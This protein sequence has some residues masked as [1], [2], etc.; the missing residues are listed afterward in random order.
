MW[1]P[2]YK[3]TY[4]LRQYKCWLLQSSIL[5]REIPVSV[6]YWT[7][8]HLVYLLIYLSYLG[9]DVSHKSVGS[10][11]N[12]AGVLLL[13]FLFLLK[14]KMLSKTLINH[15]ILSFVGGALMKVG[16]PGNPYRVVG[17]K[18]CDSVVPGIWH[19]D[20]QHVPHGRHWR[21]V[22]VVLITV[23]G[24]GEWWRAKDWL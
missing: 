15:C 17:F 6:T 22:N 7:F 16:P 14:R 24:R 9:P 10:L 20:N 21:L 8:R 19:R 12:I 3:R 4:S 11:H 13:Y 23:E 5:C 1:P 2:T 18:V